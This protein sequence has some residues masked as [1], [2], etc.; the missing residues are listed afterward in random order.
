MRS[1]PRY[2]VMSDE[3][4]GGIFNGA[5]RSLT[6][7]IVPASSKNAH[8]KKRKTNTPKKAPAA[9]K[10]SSQSTKLSAPLRYLIEQRKKPGVSF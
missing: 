5:Q 2:A 7:P 6:D 9:K 10:P 1:V 4:F 8:S 3:G